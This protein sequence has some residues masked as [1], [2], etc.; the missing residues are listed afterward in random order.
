[1]HHPLAA[2]AQSTQEILAPPLP[3]L[4]HLVGHTS[5]PFLGRTHHAL[6]AQQLYLV[7]GQT[8]SQVDQSPADDFDFR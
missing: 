8:A 1:M 7:N 6:G 5:T 3:G 4:Q 2:V